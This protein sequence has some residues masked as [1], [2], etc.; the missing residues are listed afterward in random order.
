[1]WRIP[2]RH[3]FAHFPLRATYAF[4]GFICTAI[5]EAQETYLGK[6]LSKHIILALALPIIDGMALEHAVN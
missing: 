5:V 2:S 3:F 6:G 1:M 4:T